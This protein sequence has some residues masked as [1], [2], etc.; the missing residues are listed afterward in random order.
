MHSKFICRSGSV[1][2]CEGYRQCEVC[3]HIPARSAATTA[4]CRPH[5]PCVCTGWS[6]RS[7]T[8]FLTLSSAHPICGGN[9][10]PT[11]D[12]CHLPLDQRQPNAVS[13]LTA[14]PVRASCLRDRHRC[15]P[16][17]IRPHSLVSIA[18]WPLLPHIFGW[19]RTLHWSCL[20]H[21]HISSSICLV[22][23]VSTI[24]VSVQVAEPST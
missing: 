15:F 22:C 23:S 24:T 4:T 18:T 6:I 10:P 3:I 12:S 9:H 7:V 17:A 20:L 11:T 16:F 13:Y 14:H 8:T 19:G 5:A 1:S 2:D 21:V